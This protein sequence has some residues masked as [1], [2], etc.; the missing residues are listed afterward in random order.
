MLPVT[1]KTKKEVIS[2]CYTQH[3]PWFAKHAVPTFYCS[4]W[5]DFIMKQQEK[6][7]HFHL[8]CNFLFKLLS[9]SFSKMLFFHTSGPSYSHIQHSH[10]IPKNTAGLPCCHATSVLRSF[11][12]FVFL[13]VNYPSLASNALTLWQ[14]IPPSPP[15]HLSLCVSLRL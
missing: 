2:V 4:N 12:F 7:L 8:H 10:N 3:C 15:P 13:V 9:I 11:S 5:V 14:P 1:T 6:Y